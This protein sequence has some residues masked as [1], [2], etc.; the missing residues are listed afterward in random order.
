[1]LGEA[2]RREAG[3]T[4]AGLTA[5]E[6]VLAPLGSACVAFSG[7]V[8]SALVLVVAARALGPHRVVAFTASSET[9]REAE[10]AAA[11]DFAASVGV[12]HVVRHT[13]ELDDPCFADNSPER[14]YHCKGYLVAELRAVAEREG[15]AVLI[16][17]AN[18]DDLGDHRP[19]LGAADEAGV[20][21]PLIEAGLDK[22]A[23]RA[24]S[25]FLGLSTWDRPQQACLASR[26][27]YGERITV[28]KLR[29]VAAAEDALR[30]LGFRQC[31]VRHHGPI[32]RVE[33]DEG[34]M[35]RAAGALREELVRRLR[36]LGFTYV[37]LDLAGFRSGSMNE[38]LPGR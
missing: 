12:R 15:C 10:L 35:E 2:D 22:A 14:C 29:Q 25:R 5:L 34:D 21:H 16:D 23:V 3:G 7:G 26:I 33:V 4:G 37:T 19:G 13:S 18:R 9:Y 24:L 27:P 32:A 28:E 8:D 17:G 20:R 1:M 11:R 36:A 30:E 31:R 6:G 38:A